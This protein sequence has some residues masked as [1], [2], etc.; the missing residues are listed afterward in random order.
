MI[1]HIDF[2][3]KKYFW[4]YILFPQ[5]NVVKQCFDVDDF[6]EEI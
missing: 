2:R 3:N 6:C 4:E 5:M 1:N